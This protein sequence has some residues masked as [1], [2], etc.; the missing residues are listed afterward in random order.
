MAAQ[1]IAY[2]IAYLA[3]PSAPAADCQEERLFSR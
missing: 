2:H 3:D 1:F